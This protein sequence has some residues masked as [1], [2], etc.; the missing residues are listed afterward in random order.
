MLEATC[1]NDIVEPGEACDGVANC[2]ACIPAPDSVCA[3]AT[4]LGPGAHT[5]GVTGNHGA[6]GDCSDIDMRRVDFFDVGPVPMGLYVR[7]IPPPGPGE[8][9][10]REGCTG[11][12]LDGCGISSLI[13]T[14]PAHSIL[15]IGY[16]GGPDEVTYEVRPIRFGTY[17]Y[18]TAG[19]IASNMGASWNW[20]P[21]TSGTW[22]VN[23]PGDALLVSPSIDVRG[24]EEVGL[25]F[26]HAFN[27]GILG[28]TGT[29]EYSTDGG[30]TFAVATQF[31]SGTSQATAED[32]VLSNAAG[33][34]DLRIRY[35]YEG[36]GGP[37]S[38]WQLGN[39]FVGPS[40]QP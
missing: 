27:P 20:S 2:E 36:Q 3:M 32:I 35:R 26:V 37:G 39:T 29:V 19:F 11:A 30:M 31:A 23:G 10:V 38:T 17:F 7:Q 21:G 14:K 15:W 16:A 24:I 40:F 6:F 18:D 25:H 34:E 1:G 4:E 8:L 9:T 28:A 5:L 33:A 12:V 13:Q 22:E